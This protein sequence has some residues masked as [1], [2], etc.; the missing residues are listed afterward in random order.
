MAHRP[1]K[2]SGSG[3]AFSAAGQSGIYQD[4]STT[5]TIDNP[6][7]WSGNSTLTL[8]LP[9]AGGL[10]LAGGLTTTGAGSVTQSGNGSLT[11][12]G[13]NSL[14]GT[15]TANGGTAAITSG[16]FGSANLTVG[17]TAPATMTISGSGTKVNVSNELQVNSQAT[18]GG[19]TAYLNL[20]GGTLSVAG[21][22]VVGGARMDTQPYGYKC[23]VQSERRI[24]WRQRPVDHRPVGFGSEY[25]QYHRRHAQYLR[26]ASPSARSATQ[27]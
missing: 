25:L 26:R 4:A 16:S 18:A 1:F 3:L 6:L 14:A 12:T 11:F 7:S 5:T 2:L 22:A 24:V 20:Q 21:A 17:N 27:C 13:T 9:A 19:S 15:F 10:S 8:S 23:P